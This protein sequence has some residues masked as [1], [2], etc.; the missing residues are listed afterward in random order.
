MANYRSRKTFRTEL[1]ED[2]PM[3]VGYVRVIANDDNLTYA[4]LDSTTFA[5]QYEEILEES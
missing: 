2:D 3:L 5:A 1:V 4:V